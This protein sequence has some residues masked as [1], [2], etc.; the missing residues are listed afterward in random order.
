MDISSLV[1]LLK[2]DSILYIEYDRYKLNFIINKNK[3]E[4]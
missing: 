4:L 1:E 2:N 3:E